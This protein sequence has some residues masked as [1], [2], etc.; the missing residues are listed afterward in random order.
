MI[1]SV[2]GHIDNDKLFYTNISEFLS[3]LGDVPVILGGDWNATYSQSPAHTNIDVVNMLSPRS[4]IRSGWI[5]DLC[6]TYNLLDPYRAFHPTLRDFTFIPCGARKNRSRLDFFL[7][8]D[9]L[10]QSCKSCKISPWVSVANFDHKSVAI[11]FSKD[12]VNKK[13]FINRSI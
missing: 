9:N 3:K 8:S 7:I 10:L 5:A 2:Y 13:L 12:K 1:V 6:C 4:P 11:D